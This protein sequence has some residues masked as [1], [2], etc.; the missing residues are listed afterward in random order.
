MIPPVA[1]VVL[2]ANP[3]FEKLHAHLTEKVLDVDGSTRSLNALYE[4]NRSH[5]KAHRIRQA[6]NRILCASLLAT[7]TATDLSSDLG[8]LVV[9]IASYIATAAELGLTA[10]EQGLMREDVRVFR[11]RIDEVAVCVSQRLAKDETTMKSIVAWAPMEADALRDPV[12]TSSVPRKASDLSSVAGRLVSNVRRFQSE[13]VPSARYDAINALSVLLASHAEYMHHLIRYL[14]QRKHGAEARHLIARAQFLAAVASGLEGKTETVYLE[15]RR[16]LYSPQLRDKLA[17]EAEKLRR[18]E[19]GIEMRRRELEVA[20]GEYE[21]VGGDVMRTLGRRYR[22][23]ER[24]LEGVKM[25]VEGL[26]TQQES[27]G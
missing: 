6:E 19:E 17:L 21:D 23:I 22:E 25:D 16:D 7:A 10:D 18:E 15:R 13:D 1:P 26:R 27:G 14:E 20:L 2:A 11:S 9:L 8:D 3:K 12:S 24:E 5:L 4:T